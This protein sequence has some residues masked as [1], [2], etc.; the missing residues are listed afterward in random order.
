MVC[1]NRIVQ[2]GRDVAVVGL[3]LKMYV[4]LGQR[5]EDCSSL[6]DPA[7]QCS[8]HLTLSKSRL[9]AP[10]PFLPPYST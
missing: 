2:R 10:A 9:T 6:L 4:V 8:E 5:L 7:G 3:L 1:L